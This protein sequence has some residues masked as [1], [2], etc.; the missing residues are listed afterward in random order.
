MKIVVDAG[1]GY[2]TKGKQTVDGMKEY[3]F[4]RAVAN[5]LKAEL[6][7]LKGV[8]VF[9][10]HSDEKDVPLKERTTIANELKVDLFISIHAN[11]YGYGRKWN[12]VSGIETYIY[13]SRPKEAVD[14]SNVIQRE[15]IV[16][17]GRKNRGVKTADFYVLRKTKMTAVLCECG[18]MT[19]KEEAQLLKTEAYRKKCAKAIAKAIQTYYQIPFKTEAIPSTSPSLYKVQLGAFQQ[20]ENA[21]KLAEQLQKLGYDPIIVKQQDSI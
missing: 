5:Y 3:E 16:Q 6:K 7:K 8:K 2:Q 19:N 12:G 13:K 15:L 18:F 21:E 20:K 9:F 1:H 10:S 14:L 17:T 4:N 11:A